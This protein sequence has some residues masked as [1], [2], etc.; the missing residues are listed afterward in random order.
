M[1]LEENEESD[2]RLSQR[3]SVHVTPPRLK[4]PLYSYLMALTFVCS[5][6]AAAPPP[7]RSIPLRDS[8]SVDRHTH[9]QINCCTSRSLLSVVL[10]CGIFLHSS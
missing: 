8:V 9:E 10:L 4:N 1:D 2:H 7:R 6:T 3:Y 5:D